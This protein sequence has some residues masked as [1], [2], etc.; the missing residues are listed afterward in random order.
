MK[1]FVPLNLGFG[2]I[3]KQDTIQHYTT[4]LAQ[5]IFAWGSFD[6]ALRL[7]M[8]HYGDHAFS[9]AAPLIW[10]S[11]PDDI[12]TEDSMPAFKRKLSTYLFKETFF[13]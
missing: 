8:V 5:E 7:G 2:Y 3:S 13:C 1:Y 11:L 9:Y 6:I 4:V 10:N 12:R